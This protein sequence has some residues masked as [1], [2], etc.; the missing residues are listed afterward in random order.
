MKIERQSVKGLFIN[1]EIISFSDKTIYYRLK[2]CPKRLSL[3]SEIGS[4]KEKLTIYPK[5]P[6]YGWNIVYIR[7]TDNDEL[8][9]DDHLLENL[10]N[11][12]DKLKKFKWHIVENPLYLNNGHYL[13]F[14]TKDTHRASKNLEL[15]QS[16]HLQLLKHLTND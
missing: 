12:L 9:S 5:K 8:M 16:I 1:F 13:I 2:N 4:S 14:E 15:I 3:H 6:I 7:E 10:L 11:L